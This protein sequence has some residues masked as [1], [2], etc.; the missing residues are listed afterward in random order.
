M[1]QVI[2]LMYERSALPS[3]LLK[4]DY[5]VTS[6][7]NLVTVPLKAKKQIFFKKYQKPFFL[8]L[9]KQHLLQSSVR[10]NKKVTFVLIIT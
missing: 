8:R 6:F 3:D 1:G 10:Y 4:V 9:R 7:L 5:R 2:K